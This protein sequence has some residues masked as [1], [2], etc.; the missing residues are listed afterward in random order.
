MIKFI[1]WT[2][3]SLWEWFWKDNI[4]VCLWKV[5]SDALIKKQ[6]LVKNISLGGKVLDLLILVKIIYSCFYYFLLKT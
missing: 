3:R 2:N 6:I 4:I 5:S 1:E